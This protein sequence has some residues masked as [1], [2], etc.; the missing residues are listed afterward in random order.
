MWRRA[1]V[2]AGGLTVL[3]S[4]FGLG[5]AIGWGCGNGQVYHWRYLEE[6]DAVAPI[7]AADPAFS[8]IEIHERS[9]GGIYFVGGVAAADRARLR[10]RVEQALGERRA[11]ELMAAVDVK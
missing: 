3:A 11:R 8:A 6:R 1:F 4:C 10:A 9:E 7:L 2:L 5:L